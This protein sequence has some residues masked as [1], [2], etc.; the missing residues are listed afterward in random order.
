MESLWLND[1]ERVNRLIYVSY[2][3]VISAI[4]CILNENMIRSETIF[5][6]N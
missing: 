1:K 3:Y 5:N 4:V 2:F 6:I